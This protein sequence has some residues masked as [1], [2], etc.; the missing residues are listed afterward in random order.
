MAS[1]GNRYTAPGNSST[2]LVG[3]RYASP[4]ATPPTAGS[5]A[6]AQP[7][8]TTNASGSGYSAPTGST[9]ATPE[10]TPYSPPGGFSVPSTDAAGSLPAYRP[11]STRDYVP[12]SAAATGSGS[13]YST[14]SVSPASYIPPTTGTGM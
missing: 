14:P 13:S 2:P 7:Y 9:S 4:S 10:A 3:S 8:T 6:Y 5:G 1:A 12:Q 11:G